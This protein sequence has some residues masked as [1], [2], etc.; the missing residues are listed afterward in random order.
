[1]SLNPLDRELKKKGYGTLDAEGKIINLDN[2][3]RRDGSLET[4]NTYWQNGFKAHWEDFFAPKDKIPFSPLPN[5]VLTAEGAFLGLLLFKMLKDKPKMLERIIIKYLD[6]ISGICGSIMDSGKTN[7]LTG[8]HN[9]TVLATMLH[10]LGLIDNGGYLKIVDESR[11][12]ISV[13]QAQVTAGI[14]LEGVQTF[15]EG[16][17]TTSTAGKYGITRTASGLG[18]L[19]NTKTIET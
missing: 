2:Y 8:V 5:N 14:A 13:M 18:L 6:S 1:M 12:I 19:A 7:P 16:S 17:K 15:V 3:W 11:N 9:T 4:D 10:R